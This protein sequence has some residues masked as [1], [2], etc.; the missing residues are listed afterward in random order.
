MTG[1]TLNQPFS[2]MAGVHPEMGLQKKST[3]ASQVSVSGSGVQGRREVVVA[4]AGTA[5]AL[6]L[7]FFDEDHVDALASG[8]NRGPASRGSRTEDQ[9]VGFNDLPQMP[10]R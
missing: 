6:Q 3:K 7:A 4:A 9:H 8:G 2:S 1:I 5:A 10:F